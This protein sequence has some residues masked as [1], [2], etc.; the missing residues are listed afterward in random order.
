MIPDSGPW[1]C[2]TSFSLWRVRHHRA[3]LSDSFKGAGKG[4]RPL[5][6][7][8]R[9]P[10]QMG[11]PMYLI[12]KIV[13]GVARVAARNW[14]ANEFLVAAGFEESRLLAGESL[15]SRLQPVAE[16][17]LETHDLG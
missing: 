17:V 3:I 11:E 13:H 4:D 16:S 10:S 14:R 7:G 8:H 12:A 6:P 2:S 15:L 9:R 5:Q 1:Q